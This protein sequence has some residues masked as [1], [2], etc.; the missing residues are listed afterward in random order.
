M[1][2][3][4]YQQQQTQ[5]KA[6]HHL[7]VFGS[8]PYFRPPRWELIIISHNNRISHQHQPTTDDKH[9][10]TIKQALVIPATRT[11]GGA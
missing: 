2:I 7:L 1:Y 11:L 4:I 5:N 6:I 10:S 8:A 3:T 9:S